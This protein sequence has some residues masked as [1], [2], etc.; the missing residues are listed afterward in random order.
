MK[1]RRPYQLPRAQHAYIGRRLQEIDTLMWHIISELGRVYGVDSRGAVKADQA[2][3]ALLSLRLYLE[4]RCEHEYGTGD[5][6]LNEYFRP[7]V[8]DET[9]ALPPW[10]PPA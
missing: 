10:Q 5:T 3:R 7:M 4:G 1:R 2:R 9:S 8:E 6:T